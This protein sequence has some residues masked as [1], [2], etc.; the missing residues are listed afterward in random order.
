MQKNNIADLSQ[1]ALAIISEAESKITS[2]NGNKVILV[3]Y[4]AES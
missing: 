2:I 1:E 4:S 3:A